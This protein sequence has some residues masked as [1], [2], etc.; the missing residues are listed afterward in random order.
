ME[1]TNHIA[2][3]KENTGFQQILTKFIPYWPLFLITLIIS[4]ACLYFYLKFTIPI[5]ETTASVLI[6]DEKKGQEDS[7]MEEVLNVFGTKKIVE[8]ELEIFHSNSLIISVVKTLNLYAPI[9][10]EKGWRGLATTSAYL[11]SPVIIEVPDPSDI[12]E[13]SKIY[14]RFSKTDS[15]IYINETKYPLNEWVNSPWGTIRFLKNPHYLP[16]TKKTSGIVKYYF[17]LVTLDHSTNNVLGNLMVSAASKQSSIITLSIKDPI[18]LRG[19]AII[20][21]IVVAYNQASAERKSS[22]AYKTLRFIEE[23]LKNASKEL[24]SVEG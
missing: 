18:P 14:F 10:E 21:E 13:T 8:N 15:T 12:E 1:K 22:I 17:N 2:L 16:N 23:R 11:T 20:S 19:E 7:K 3:E 9:F 24:D 5:Y 6:K 4:G